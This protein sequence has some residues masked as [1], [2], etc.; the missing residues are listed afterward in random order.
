MNFWSRLLLTDLCE[1]FAH[2]EVSTD[3]YSQFVWQLESLKL[4]KAPLEENPKL[5]T[6][7]K[8]TKTS[9]RISAEAICETGEGGAKKVG[10]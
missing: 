9:V 3:F 1:S 2:L 5:Q 4:H 6:H 8:L 10:I 7:I